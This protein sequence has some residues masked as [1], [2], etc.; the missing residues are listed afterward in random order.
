MP[1]HLTTREFVT[2]LAR[3]LRDGGILAQNV[4]DLPPLDFLRAE[5]AT[6]R[7][8]FEH[9]AV[10]APAPRLAGDEGG[11]FIVV[12][13]DRPLP[14]DAIERANAAR[15]DDDQ[16]LGD[17]AAVDEFIGGADVLTDEHAPVD[18]LIS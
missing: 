17:P 12:A 1:W 4:I 13:S 6:M 18:Q 10:I 7:D 8:V 16:V 9:V 2:E 15:G 5:L 14:L 11:N 3:V